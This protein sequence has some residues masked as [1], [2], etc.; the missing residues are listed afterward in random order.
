[1]EKY[2]VFM[3]WKINIVKMPILLKVIYRFST[4]PVK[5]LM[6]LFIEIEQAT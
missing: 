4:I 1:M 6:K 2:S 5:I 3:D